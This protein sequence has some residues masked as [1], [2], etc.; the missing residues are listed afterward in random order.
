VQVT[1]VADRG[2]SDIKL[3]R[4]LQE[5]GFDDSKRFRR[6]V[7]V[8]SS[9]G[10]RGK[11]KNWLG[12][13]GRR[14]VLRGARVTAEGQPVPMVVCVPQQQMQEPWRLA[15][16]CSELTGT[17]IKHLYGKRFTGEETCRDVKT[18]AWG[19]G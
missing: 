10:E 16:R 5:L 18:P 4:Y 15:S 19:W 6:V 13:G 14:R 12:A 1:V 2:F 7:S 9:S 8:E 3:S 17:A 11:A